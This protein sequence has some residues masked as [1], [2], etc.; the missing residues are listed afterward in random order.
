MASIW[1]RFGGKERDAAISQA[2]RLL[3]REIGGEITDETVDSDNYY[4]PNYAVYEQALYM[5]CNSSAVVNGQET[6]PKYVSV[7][8]DGERKAKSK[9]R[10]VICAEAIRWLGK[11]KHIVMFARG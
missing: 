3:S 6:G 1:H 7:D 5:L 8:L 10:A 4:Q 11:K 9:D 2:Q